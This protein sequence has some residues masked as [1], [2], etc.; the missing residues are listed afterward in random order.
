MNGESFEVDVRRRAVNG[1]D[2]IAVEEMDTLAEQAVRGIV[3]DEP[4]YTSRQSYESRAL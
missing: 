3:A 2:A 1:L 4:V